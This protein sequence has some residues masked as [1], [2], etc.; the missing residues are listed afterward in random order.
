MKKILLILLLL[1]P[2]VAPAQDFQR[3]E[4][5]DSLVFT[6][7]NPVDSTLRGKTIYSAMPSNVKVNQ[8]SAIANALAGRTASNTD[9]KINGYRIRIYFDN[10][11]DARGASSSVVYRFKKLYPGIPAYRT[12]RSPYF[13]VTVGDYRTRSEALAV[14]G[15]IQ[16]DFPGAFIVREPV[17]FPMMSGEVAFI[18]DTVKVR[19]ILQ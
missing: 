14:L 11:R 15:G 6:V 2:L 5:V 17:R 4:I 18:V 12:F 9:R 13:K 19:R 10:S 1:M 3:Y 16:R 7:V 8:S